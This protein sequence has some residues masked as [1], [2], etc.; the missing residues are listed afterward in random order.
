MRILPQAENTTNKNEVPIDDVIAHMQLLYYNEAIVVLFSQWLIYCLR[1]SMQRQLHFN[2]APRNRILVTPVLSLEN[3]NEN[4][5]DHNIRSTIVSPPCS[6]VLAHGNQSRY[7][8]KKLK[9]MK[10]QNSLK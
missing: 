4:T 6:Y 8:V 7:L 9:I 5:C 3:L 10:A 2:D 1:K